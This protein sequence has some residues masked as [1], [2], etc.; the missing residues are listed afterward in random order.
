MSA[1]SICRTAA[2]LVSGDRAH[3]HGDILQNMRAIADLWNAIL[4][5]KY[6]AQETP[7]LNALDV[8][9][10]LEA[11]KIARR[12]T[13]ALNPDDFIDA[14]GYAGIAGEIADRLK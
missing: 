9:C 2:D 14:A 3:M 6:R 12:Y 5:I 8:A 13:G 4:T 11:L 10:M 7:H 1:A